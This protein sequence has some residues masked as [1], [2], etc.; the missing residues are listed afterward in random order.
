MFVDQPRK[1]LIRWTVTLFSKCHHQG[2]TRTAWN[3]TA[4]TNQISPQMEQL[5][6]P[7]FKR[8]KKF[9]TFHLTVH[10]KNGLPKKIT[11]HLVWVHSLIQAEWMGT[12]WVQVHGNLEVAIFGQT[13]KLKK[14]KDHF[15]PQLIKRHK[16]T[17]NQDVFHFC[18]QFTSKRLI[19]QE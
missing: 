7:H 14:V 11:K 12:K 4:I 15:K 6:L 18:H 2:K 13:D 16:F 17:Q 9:H 8:N 10:L 5:W 19:Q 3:K 1:N